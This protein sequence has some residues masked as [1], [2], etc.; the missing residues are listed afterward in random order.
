MYST[1]DNK[2]KKNIDFF[3]EIIEKSLFTDRQISI[4]YNRSIGG[5]ID[6]TIT[7]GAYYRQIKQCRNKVESLI[8]SII[9][10]RL[11]NTLN[12][13][14]ISIIESLITQL[15][16]LS[17]ND[18]NYYNNNIL[19]HDVIDVIDKIVKKSVSI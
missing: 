9:L 7:S 2:E 15:S 8:Y 14:T 3:K 19:S 13:G 11:I 5:Q 12:N 6:K 17:T 4:I 10:L 18:V 16:S 1:T